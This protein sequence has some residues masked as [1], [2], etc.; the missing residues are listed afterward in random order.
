MSFKPLILKFHYQILIRIHS[1]FTSIIPSNNVEDTQN[2]NRNFHIQHLWLLYLM[3]VLVW[4]FSVF[5]GHVQKKWKRGR[6]WKRGTMFY[7]FSCFFFSVP[8]KHENKQQPSTTGSWETQ[9]LDRAGPGPR[10]R[11]EVV[12]CSAFP[13]SEVEFRW[14][15]EKNLQVWNCKYEGITSKQNFH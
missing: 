9:T 13:L 10:A 15:T 5:S 12:W 8:L 4:Q 14:V 11:L 1:I 6:M 7:S 3:S 2:E